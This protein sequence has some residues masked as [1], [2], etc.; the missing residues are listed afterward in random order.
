MDRRKLIFIFG[1]AWLSAAL[2]TWL[3]WAGTKAPKTDKTVPVVAATHDMPAGWRLRK[4]DLKTVK[5]ID[6]DVPR[7]AVLDEKTALDRVLLFPV[8]SSEVL[9]VS[10]LTSLNGAEGLPATIEPGKRAISIPFTDQTGVAGLIQPRSHV[11]VLFTRPG[12]MT[13]AV[14]T[15]VLENVVVLSIGRNTEV[16]PS[17]VV[18]G[19]GA[20]TPT[21]PVV[22]TASS[23]ATRA[24]TLMVTPAEARKLEW[25]RNQGKL[26]LS[27]R[28]PL[29]HG[30]SA[31]P[32]PTTAL[33][34]DL[35]GYMRMNGKRGAMPNVRDNKLW[36]QLTG[37]D[38]AP[39][40]PVAVEKKEPPKPRYIVDVYR[41]DKH[42]QEIFQ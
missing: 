15:T 26:S 42:V 36:A 39:K 23:T 22:S 10:R 29:D 35:A 2:L 19:S 31:D 17:Y 12:S 6:K 30:V 4:T 33:D 7:T 38:D 14:T 24:A 13:E 9:T 32:Q 8:N 40:K 41:G 21:T 27:L 5:V 28:N 20:V 18:S 3:L 11:D 1:G 16:T 25:A 34:L 37:Q